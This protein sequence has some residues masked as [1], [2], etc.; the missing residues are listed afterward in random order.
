MRNLLLVV[1]LFSLGL[2]FSGCGGKEDSPKT[3]EGN[4]KIADVLVS[5]VSVKAQI[6][7]IDSAPTI[8]FSSTKIEIEGSSFDYIIKEGYVCNAQSG[9]QMFKFWFSGSRLTL[10]LTPA[11]LNDP[12]ISQI[13]GLEE[14]GDISALVDSGLVKLQIQMNKV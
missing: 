9:V 5:G 10:E 13:L 2:I 14:L 4:W 1:A 8:S 6:P 12:A 11:A 7:E 3:L